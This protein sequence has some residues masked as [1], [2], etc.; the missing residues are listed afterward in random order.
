MKKK[1]SIKKFVIDL[2][3]E[4]CGCQDKKEAMFY[5]APDTIGSINNAHLDK[6]ANSF[7]TDF[8]TTDGRNMKFHTKGETFFKWAGENDINKDGSQDDMIKNFLVA[9]LTN[10]E[11]QDQRQYDQ[12]LEEIVDDMGNLIGNNDQPNN[13]SFNMIGTSHLDTDKAVTQSVPK[14]KRFYSS[15]GTG[16]ISW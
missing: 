13:S 7:S 14:S 9:F 8:S 11:Q 12:P 4:D 15:Y 10:S 6:K 2:I 5:L 3:K 1:L 16:Y